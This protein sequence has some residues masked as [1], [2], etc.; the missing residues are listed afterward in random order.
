M[1]GSHLNCKEYDHISRGNS[2][3]FTLIDE[4]WD[5]SVVT[6]IESGHINKVALIER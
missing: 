3:C 2:L 5:C 1:D 4:I 6:L